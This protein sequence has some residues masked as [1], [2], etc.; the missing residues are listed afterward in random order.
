MLICPT[1]GSPK[2]QRLSLAYEAGT[3]Q[4]GAGT[5]AGTAAGDGPG[6]WASG[7]S[8]SACGGCGQWPI[9]MRG[10]RTVGPVGKR[11]F[12][13]GCAGRNFRQSS[14]DRRDCILTVTVLVL[15]R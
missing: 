13:V 1:C 11:R 9:T 15:L 12:S 6:W 10:F 3:S 2:V 4:L 8:G 5:A 7:C 14:P